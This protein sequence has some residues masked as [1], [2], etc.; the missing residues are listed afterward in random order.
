M[1][2]E[3][4]KEQWKEFFDGL[5]RDL[6][7][8]DT[9]VEVIDNN[10]GAQVLAEGMPFHGLTAETDHTGEFTISISVGNGM[11]GHQTHSIATPF[12]VSF[13][14]AAVGPGGVLEIEDAGASKM[15]IT[16][17]Q[18]IPVLLEYTNTEIIAVASTGD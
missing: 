13:E 11:E 18:P 6:E 1:A 3:I 17:I 12:K 2:R 14:S 9:R 4:P 8:W 10:V 7:Y 16:F 5:S 15:L